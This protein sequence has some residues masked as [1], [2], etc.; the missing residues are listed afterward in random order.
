MKRAPILPL[1]RALTYRKR[2][3]SPMVFVLPPGVVGV[4]DDIY[5]E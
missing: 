1:V 4:R 5:S 2:T 3:P